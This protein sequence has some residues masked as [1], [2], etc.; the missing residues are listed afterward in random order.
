MTPSPQPGLSLPEQFLSSPGYTDDGNPEVN[1]A[2][3]EVLSIPW[4]RSEGLTINLALF[5]LHML[6]SVSRDVKHSY[7][8]IREDPAYSI[9]RQAY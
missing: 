4:D 2:D 5:A 8:G 1:M 3:L 6:A 9:F 7:P